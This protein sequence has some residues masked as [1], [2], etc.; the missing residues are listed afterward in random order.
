V[1]IESPGVIYIVLA[2]AFIFEGGSWLVSFRQFR[3]RKA[4]SGSLT[5]S[6]SARIHLIHDSV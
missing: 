6:A 1:P 3:K 4:T 2:L 5:L